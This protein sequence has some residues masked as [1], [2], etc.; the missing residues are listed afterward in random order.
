[1]IAVRNINNGTSGKWIKM[2]VIVNQQEQEQQ[3]R[4]LCT[5]TDWL[6]SCRSTKLYSP[7]SVGRPDFRNKRGSTS[8]RSVQGKHIMFSKRYLHLW[9]ANFCQ[10]RKFN[11]HF[12][13]RL[14]IPQPSIPIQLLNSFAVEQSY[15]TSL[16]ILLLFPPSPSLPLF[17]FFTLTCWVF[18]PPHPHTTF[19]FVCL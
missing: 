12:L 6:T 5:A 3:Q 15:G 7:K 19:P 2:T 17:N 14:A 8:T 9:N 1:M 18:L 16:Q 4:K 10:W 11:F 13:P